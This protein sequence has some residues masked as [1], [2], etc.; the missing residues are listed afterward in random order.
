M[1]FT[2]AEVV[3]VIYKDSNTDFL[4]EVQCKSLGPSEGSDEGDPAI[5]SARPLN[6]YMRTIPLKGEVVAI[7]NAPSSATTALMTAGD[8]YYIS[9]INI[10]SLVNHNTV[11][12]IS[13]VKKLFS[14]GLNGSVTGYQ[15]SSAGSTGRSSVNPEIDKNFNENGNAA[16]IQGY[17]GDIILEGRYGQS[18]RFSSTVKNEGND[19]YGRGYLYSAPPPWL[20]DGGKVGD[21]ITTIRNSRFVGSANK[22]YTENLDK[23][24]SLIILTSDQKLGLKP[25]VDKKKAATDVGINVPKYDKNQIHLISGRLVFNARQQEILAYAKKGIHMA[26]DKIALDATN[27]ITLDSPSINLGAQAIEPIILGQQWTTWMANFIT[28]LGACIVAT[29]VGPSGPLIANPAWPQIAQ[30]QA[31][32][33]TLLSKISKTK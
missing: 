25:A 9:I 24:D 30:L 11:P 17:Y 7:I 13:A 32:L 1:S 2:F 12:T 4:H 10:H 22:F 14:G 3:R 23:D 28:A 29:G 5:F 31:Q 26:S 27:K 6:P 19:A 8:S 33:P 20:K 16:F 18:V 15:A 21:P